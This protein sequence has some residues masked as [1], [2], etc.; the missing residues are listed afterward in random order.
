MKVKPS[1]QGKLKGEM[2]VLQGLQLWEDIEQQWAWYPQ[3]A[4]VSDY[5]NPKGVT[6]SKSSN[7]SHTGW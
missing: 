2:E 4:V 5:V 7:A 3:A 6:I 1:E